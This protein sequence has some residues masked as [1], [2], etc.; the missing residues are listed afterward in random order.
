MWWS[1]VYALVLML[2]WLVFNKKKKLL[3]CALF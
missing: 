3:P 2:W 1:F